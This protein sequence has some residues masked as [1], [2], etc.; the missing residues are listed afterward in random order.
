[1]DYDCVEQGVTSGFLSSINF[2]I[3]TDED[4]EKV[5]VKEI[6]VPNDVIHPM[7]G[8]PTPMSS[9]CLTCDA[10]NVK[11][12]EGHFGF[13]KFPYPVLHPYF[14]S[15]V[16]KILN[17]ICVKCKS[18]RI[19]TKSASSPSTKRKPK[20]KR[21]C[22]KYC[23][24]RSK[25]EYPR[26]IFKV[27][28]KE[29][30]ESTVILA[31]INERSRTPRVA[32][33]YWDF[34]QNDPQEGNTLKP[35]E[36]ILTYTQVQELLKGIDLRFMKDFVKDEKNLL[37]M[38]NFPVTPNSHRVNECGQQMRFDE[39]T[40]F[41]RKLVDFKGPANEL[42]A[43]VLDCLKMAKLKP[44]KV[45][46]T[47]NGPQMFHNF[48]DAAPKMSGLKF[49]KELI[50]G[51]RSDHTF[52]MVV[53]GD[54]SIKIDEIGVPCHI[55]QAMQISEQLNS[56]NWENL[57][58]RILTRGETYVR[59]DGGLVRVTMKNDKL[60]M[61]D[62]IHRPLRDGDMV[63]INRPPSIHPHS[64]IALSVKILPTNSILSLN[65]LIC[66]PFRGDFDGDCYHGYVPQ[67]MDSKVE[68]HELVA[69]DKQLIN[70]QSGQNLLSLTH[71]SLTAAHLV[72]EDEVLLNRP[73]MQQLQ[74][75]CPQHRSLQLPAIFKASSTSPDTHWWTGK[76]LFSL[77]LPPDFSYNCPSR[78]VQVSEGEVI[79]FQSASSWLRDTKGN[80]LYKLLS[81]CQGEFLDFL[82]AAQRVLGEW[83]STR[84]LSVSLA[85]M[86][87]SSDP[88]SQKNM[89]EEVRYGLQ[90]AQYVSH[91]KLLMVDSNLDF[92]SG[93][94][95][96]TESTRAFSVDHSFCDQQKSA[97]LSQVSVGA[98]K[99]V[100][101]NIQNLFYQYASED[102]SF[103]AMLKAGSK[104]C[105]LTRAVQ[106]GLCLGLQHSLV[107]LSFKI[108]QQLSCL[109]WNYQKELESLDSSADPPEFSSSYIP[110]AVI[111]SS[112]L[113]G[114]NPLESFVHSLTSR[115]GSFGGHADIS[116]TLTRRIM[117]FMRDLCM[118]YDGTVRSAFGNQVVQ[119]FYGIST[120][121]PENSDET[122]TDGACTMGG[123]PVGSWAACAI[124][125]AAYSALDQPI[126]AFEP[127]PLLNL[128]EILECGGNKVN[129]TASLFFSKKLA[130]WTYGFEYAAL[131]VKN[132][133]ER[134][135]FSDIV[136]TVMIMFSAETCGQ[137]RDSPWVCHFHIN[138]VMATRKQIKVQ[139]VID[140]LKMK[141][142]STRVKSNAHLPD[143]KF[144]S[145]S[146]CSENITSVCIN[147]RIVGSNRN[148]GPQLETLEETVIPL[149]LKS[150]IKGS[151]N[152]HKV[153]ILWKD[154]S[155]KST[156]QMGVSGELY[157]RVFMSE[158]C[159]RSRFWAVLM[160]DCLQLMDLIDWKRSYPEDIHAA[161]SAFGIDFAKTQFLSKLASALS[162]TGKAVLP[163]H[164]ILI[165]DCL[166][167][168]GEF[169]ALSASGLARQR[170]QTA[171]S[172]PFTQA[173]FS[174]PSD[175]FINAGKMGSMDKLQGSIDALAW[176]NSPSLGTGAQFDIL[177][178]GKGHE[179]D[180]PSDIY[181][182]LGSGV[183]T[184]EQ[185]VKVP[186]EFSNISI[187]SL[188]K[189]SDFLRKNFKATHFLWMSK[190]LRHILHKYK[191]NQQL[192]ELDEAIAAAALFFHPRSSEKIGCG[193]QGIKIGL[194]LKGETSQCFQ[195]IR[196][197]GTIEEFSYHKCI[198][199][200]L[201]QTAPRSAETYE[202]KWLGER[203]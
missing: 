105:N 103:L 65:P 40:R 74:M 20:R 133:L 91:V 174:S 153:D 118:A 101:K 100:F 148:S 69:L 104:K 156:S 111:Q 67:S 127:S 58:L 175:C 187:K 176:G 122:L 108:P 126:S 42:S 3:V 134:V 112:F 6:E 81:H 84:G 49:I 38:N 26:T 11:T 198:L 185:K 46:V 163:E 197:D 60:R 90:E 88:H 116:G 150:V 37:S 149:L 165:A 117:F 152:V 68:L 17:R 45:S 188:A 181:N 190:E 5:S 16:V 63:L 146:E 164:S 28:G 75:F 195:L 89:I 113:S 157:V 168:T 2:G 10:K 182:L 48:E 186:R 77:L 86:Y 96:E 99:Q 87:L 53:V 33:D 191:V 44:E 70:I 173:C 57:G 7:L 110:Y 92:L 137:S 172:S 93:N 193:L 54:P 36:R 56:Q 184:Q 178:S 203:L 19:R 179:V 201:K 21:G 167:L 123:Q 41:Y 135:Q 109:T 102:N 130:R 147:V 107:P 79:C 154:I 145:N 151:S 160:G 78:A 128:K 162:D 132:R 80:L 35:H 138:K 95:E 125:E 59:R 76:Q 64:L 50:L 140:A 159:D 83:L 12:C 94:H 25:D 31:R 29:M 166:S 139:S 8:I 120:T 52:R 199:N 39:R 23:D 155:N 142:N 121:A 202:S 62:T 13:I 1:M 196:T 170:K 180:K 98:F 97:A 34:L 43:R 30:F 119:F 22:C 47:A 73:Q 24:G 32:S 115:D 200:A 18:E 136:S 82:H 194:S 114:L 131:E 4:V 183:G 129:C 71:D 66:S 15:D 72:I 61:G 141:W 85:D 51:K 55:A 106:H 192:I 9:Q 171:V 143:L 189:K 177:Y 27:S 161:A 144:T 124:S 158:T 14:I 169:V